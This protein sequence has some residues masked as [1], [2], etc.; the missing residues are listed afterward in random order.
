MEFLKIR[1][2]LNSIYNEEIKENLK[3]IKNAKKLYFDGWSSDCTTTE[4]KNGKANRTTN[5]K[6]NKR[7]KR[8]TNKKIFKTSRKRAR[9]TNKKA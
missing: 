9:K 4:D 6:A 5:T 7:T 2:V 3:A 1:K 8:N